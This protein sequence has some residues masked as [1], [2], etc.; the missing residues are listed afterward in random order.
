MSSCEQS[1]CCF[2][3]CFVFGTQWVENVVGE[4]HAPCEA[5]GK[6]S[7]WSVAEDIGSKYDFSFNYMR[8]KYISNQGLH[9]DG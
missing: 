3:C 8:T 5:T 7:G 2:N 9:G 4:V 1:R 6:E